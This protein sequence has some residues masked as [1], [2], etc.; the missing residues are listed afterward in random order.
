M[1]EFLFLINTEALAY[2]KYLKSEN[3]QS[4]FTLPFPPMKCDTSVFYQ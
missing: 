1:P 2:T 3:L 4:I